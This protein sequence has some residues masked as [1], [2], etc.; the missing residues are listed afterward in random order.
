MKAGWKTCRSLAR[1]FSMTNE[2]YKMV[3]I[4]WS[5]LHKSI[6]SELD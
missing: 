5:M 2:K 6:K 4:K 3:N 1:G